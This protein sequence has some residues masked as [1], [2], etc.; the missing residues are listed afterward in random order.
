ME[1]KNFNSGE[2]QDYVERKGGSAV[3]MAQKDP[4]RGP[5]AYAI[6]GI[7]LIFALVACSLAATEWGYHDINGECALLE[8]TDVLQEDAVKATCGKMAA[9]STLKDCIKKMCGK[10]NDVYYGQCVAPQLIIAGGVFGMIAAMIA[11]AGDFTPA[12]MRVCATAVLSLCVLLTFF[13]SMSG[14]AT[15]FFRFGS[16]NIDD[17]SKINIVAD[18]T[19]PDCNYTYADTRSDYKA[20]TAFA[21]LNALFTL[22]LLVHNCLWCNKQ[23]MHEQQ[24]KMGDMEASASVENH[25]M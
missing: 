18:G 6:M 1:Y 10:T 21:F 8:R 22:V 15:S 23:R 12:G 13:L 7:A 25:F 20:M 24:I 14:F 11:A 2:V 3:G 19:S 5:E 16:G 9:G 4:Q 17:S